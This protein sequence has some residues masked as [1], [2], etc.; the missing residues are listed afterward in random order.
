MKKYLLLIVVG[1][2]FV[3][4]GFKIEPINFGEKSFLAQVHKL[5]D[6]LLLIPVDPQETDFKSEEFNGRFY[7]IKQKQTTRGFAYLGRVNGCEAGGCEIP[8]P[9]ENKVFEYFDYYAVFDSLGAVSAIDIFN[10]KATHGK[11]VCERDWLDQFLGYNGRRNLK[12]GVTVDAISGATTSTENFSLDL[13]EATRTI[14]ALIV[15]NSKADS[16]K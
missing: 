12:V 14:R 5:A 15:R 9:G 1:I 10:Y 16:I 13:Q 3:F 7:Y 6:S 2:A 11:E 4:V 8:K